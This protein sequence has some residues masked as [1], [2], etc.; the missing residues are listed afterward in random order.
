MFVILYLLAVVGIIVMAPGATVYWDAFGYVLQALNGDVGGLG[1]GRPVFVLA[2][3][4]VARAWLGA[5]GS[6]WHL[7]IVLRLACALAASAAAPLTARL[8]LDCGGSRRAAWMAGLAVALSPAMAHASG[9]VLADGPGASLLVL[10][11][12]LGVRTTLVPGKAIAFGLASGVAL[13]LAIGVREQTVVNVLTLAWLA[14]LAPRATRWRVAAAMSIGG[15]LAVTLPLAYV[16]LA[17]PAYL[18]TVRAWL[19]NMSRDRIAKTYG[20][21]DLVIYASW[22]LS[23]GPVVVVAG[24]SALVLAMRRRGWLSPLIAAVAAPAVLQ[25]LWMATFRGIAYSPRF[26]IAAL[27]GAFA[28]PASILVTRWSGGSLARWRWAIVAWALPMAL[29]APITHARSAALVATMR[30]WPARLV[31]LRSPAVVVTGQPCP[32]IPLVRAIV[33][34]GAPSTPDWQPVCPGWAWPSNL[35]ARLDRA[36]GEGR[37]VAVDLRD[38]SWTGD[39][40]RAARDELGRYVVAHAAAESSGQMVVWR[41]DS[42]QRP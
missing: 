11:C 25:V 38:A 36:I 24:S 8:A 19:A 5:G 32:A 34:L 17:E 18:D 16:I 27:P 14:W 12:V 28:I 13:G 9:Q 26:L 22:L 3:H 31:A 23:L 30:E 2:L 20:W 15:F 35:S 39:E 42:R 40:Q 1:L 10:A 6:P 41:G 4:G 21:R 33:G 37:L 29:A 7:E